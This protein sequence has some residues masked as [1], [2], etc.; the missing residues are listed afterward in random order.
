MAADTHTSTMKSGWPWCGSVLGVGVLGACLVGCTQQSPPPPTPGTAVGAVSGT[1]YGCFGPPKVWTVQVT[2]TQSG[3]T[4]DSITIHAHLIYD[5]GP[6][7]GSRLVGNAYRLVLP[8]GA[9]E[10]TARGA[11]LPL[12]FDHMV[13]V[14]AGKTATASW[15]W[16]C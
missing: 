15:T 12:G 14:R 10:M 13:I 16:A 1:L 4:K 6:G 8:V 2:A 7:S 5:H 3:L 9:Y 11:A